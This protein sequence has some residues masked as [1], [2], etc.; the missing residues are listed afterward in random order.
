MCCCVCGC[1]LIFCVSSCVMCGVV[2]IE[3]VLD[4]VLGVLW[5]V[6]LKWFIIVCI[7]C[8]RCCFVC[9]FCLIGC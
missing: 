5:F 6:I 8:C 1:L 2:M 3:F 7:G 4:G 9:C